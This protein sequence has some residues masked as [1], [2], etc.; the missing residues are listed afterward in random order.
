ME[1]EMKQ[2]KE[3][4][5]VVV[6]EEGFATIEEPSFCMTFSCGAFLGGTTK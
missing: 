4:E 5:E 2:N 1:N 3:N 6:L